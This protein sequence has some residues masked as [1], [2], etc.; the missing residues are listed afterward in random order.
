MQLSKNLVDIAD[1][2]YENIAV[3]DFSSFII[4]DFKNDILLDL[5]SEQA[6]E[7]ISKSATFL[8]QLKYLQKT[9][10]TEDEAAIIKSLIDF[11]QYIKSSS[12]FYWHKFNSHVLHHQ[13]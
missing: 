3:N 13:K 4:S 2:Y 12:E 11:A 10:L 8:A 5:S 6:A 9:E 7:N 1:K